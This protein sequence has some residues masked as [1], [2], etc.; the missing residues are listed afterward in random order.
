MEQLLDEERWEES[1]DPIFGLPKVA[2]R[3]S[4]AGKKVKKEKVDETI[5]GE[6]TPAPAAE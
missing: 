1:R 3:K 4:V 5:E 6:A 2:H